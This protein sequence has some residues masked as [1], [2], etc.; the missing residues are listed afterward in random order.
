MRTLACLFAFASA[1][2]VLSS[3]AAAQVTPLPADVVA[4]SIGMNLH[5]EFFGKAPS[6]YADPAYTNIIQTELIA[7]G[8]RYVRSGA[9]AP[10]G[11]SNPHKAEFF[12]R[13]MALVNAGIKLTI[14]APLIATIDTDYNSSGGWYQAE[15]ANEPDLAHQ[16]CNT[17]LANQ[18]SLYNAVKGDPLVS[19]LPVLGPSL[20]TTNSATW[21]RTCSTFAGIADVGNWHTYIHA[22]NPEATG[23][24]HTYFANAQALY[25]AVPIY[26]TEY[27]YRSVQ[28][29]EVAHQNPVPGAPDAIIARYMPRWI[30]EKI[31]I[32]YTRGFIH[33]I[34][35]NHVPSPTDPNSGY[36]M[37]DYYGTIKPQWNAVKNMLIEFADPSPVTPVPLSYTVTRVSGNSAAPLTML[38][39]RSDGKYLLPIWLGLSGWNGSTYVLTPVSPEVVSVQLGTSAPSVNIDTFN[40]DGTMS[41]RTIVPV[42]GLFQMTVTDHLQVLIF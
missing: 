15:G 32:G 36:G 40:D 30:V 12:A 42:N 4:D 22:V 35:D 5:P 33:Q 31:K 25:P 6:V 3:I 17:I 20:T 18:Q 34:A 41:M 23:W 2:A 11:D 10:S 29:G 16:P 27:G 1:A 26:A 39:Q 28:A 37:I 19:S 8:I 13:E 7:S 14:T 9:E 38:F 24:D 21:L